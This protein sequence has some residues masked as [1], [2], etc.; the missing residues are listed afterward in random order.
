[1]T[2]RLL[3]ILCFSTESM[4]KYL[5]FNLLN[6]IILGESDLRLICTFCIESVAEVSGSYDVCTS[7]QKCYYALQPRRPQQLRLVCL[8]IY[9]YIYF[10]AKEAYVPDVLISQFE[11]EMLFKYSIK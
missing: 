11:T 3:E 7:H 5:R 10:L 2:H 1:M 6:P 9:I 8:V 4:G